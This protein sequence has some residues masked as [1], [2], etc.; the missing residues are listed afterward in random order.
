MQL[1]IE[2]LRGRYPQAAIV[3]RGSR[4]SVVDM[5]DGVSVVVTRTAI[6]VSKR[7]VG[8]IGS[9]LPAIACPTAL[10]DRI[11]EAKRR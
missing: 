8:M 2:T 7:D 6:V 9:A 4:Q 10:L 5:G 1:L 11:A 3:Q